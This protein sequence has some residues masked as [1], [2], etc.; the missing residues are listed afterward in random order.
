MSTPVH[1]D[2]SFGEGGGQI[3]RSSL[4]LSAA[5]GRPLRVVRIRAGRKK[6]GLLAQHLAAVRA[7]AIVSNAHVDGDVLG[8]DRL[9]FVP[10]PVTAPGHDVPIDVGTAGATS[11]VAHAVVPALLHAGV[12]A[13]FTIAGGTHVDMAPTY[14]HLREAW[15]PALQRMGHAVHL[16]LGAHGF[17]P[18]G[19]GRLHVHVAARAHA[20][21]RL[22]LVERGKVR[23]LRV[24]LVL[25]NRLRPD[26]AERELEVLRA[27][28]PRRI[29]DIT[30]VSTTREG[31]ALMVVVE[32][33]AGVDVF[34]A[35]GAR[36]VRAQEVAA[37]LADEVG[38]FV[39]A[40]VPVGE[41]LADQLLLPMALGA[42]GSFLTVRPSQHTLTNIDV[43]R[44]FL[45]VEIA[46][47]RLGPDRARIDVRT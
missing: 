37:G 40:D 13:R 9:D 18:R 24:V 8:S 6:P 17:F 43:I 22:E 35:L 31:N 36:G 7:V 11:L 16:D 30:R 45:D 41:H 5:T 32:T 3:L 21:R 29:D 1:I 26:I 44:R 4:S 33:E 19:G 10:S 46:V 20:P 34:Q 39:R 14:E 47:E 42:G 12:E 28:L 15:A 23:A 2:G 25:G 38:A 27:R